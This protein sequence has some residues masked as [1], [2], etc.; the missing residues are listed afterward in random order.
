MMRKIVLMLSMQLISCIPAIAG[1]HCSFGSCNTTIYKTYINKEIN[2][3]YISPMTYVYDVKDW[4]IRPGFGIP[5]IVK[6]TDKSWLEVGLT[7][8]VWHTDFREGWVA[9]TKLM[10]DWTALDFTKK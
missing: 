5:K 8:D 10:I 1:D 4:E 3:T 2:K 9:E 6:F 7:K